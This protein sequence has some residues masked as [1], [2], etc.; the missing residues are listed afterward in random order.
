MRW[1]RPT[2]GDERIIKRFTFMPIEIKKEVRWLELC[3][4]KQEWWVPMRIDN[5]PYWRNI[6]FATKEEYDKFKRGNK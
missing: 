2:E 3:Y 1:R 5:D 4:I 6:A